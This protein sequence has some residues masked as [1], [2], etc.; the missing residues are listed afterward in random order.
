[1][2]WLEDKIRLQHILEEANEVRKFSKGYSFD[3]LANDS[4]TVH[5]IIRAIEIIGEA[6]SKISEEYKDKHPEIHWGQIIGMRNHLIHVYFDID[7][8]TVWNTVQKDIPE[9]IKMATKLLA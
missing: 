4:K 2:P 7:Y 6:A 3:D 8:D 9:L 5:A 1:M